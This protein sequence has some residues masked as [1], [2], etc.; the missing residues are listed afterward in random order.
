M[1]AA[2]FVLERDRESRPIVNIHQNRK[3]AL[4]QGLTQ[5]K[6][7]RGRHATT[8]WRDQH[9]IQVAALMAFLAEPAPI[10]PHLQIGGVTLQKLAQPT[11]ARRAKI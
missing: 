5:L 8:L 10:G 1:A 6:E 11:Q 3:V 9:K 4:P 7:L 2:D